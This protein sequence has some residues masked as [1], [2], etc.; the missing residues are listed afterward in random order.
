MTIP[1]FTHNATLK[2]F[3][4]GVLAL[5]LL[6]PTLWLDSLV[7][8]RKH[9][10]QEAAEEVYTMWG[11]PQ[12]IGS[13]I[14]V[15]P[16][17]YS[18][19]VEVARKRKTNEGWIEESI[20]KNSSCV[21]YTKLYPERLNITGDL[22]STQRK[23]GIFQI[24]LYTALIHYDFTYATPDWNRLG[25]NPQNIA[26]DEAYITLDIRDTRGLLGEPQL[27]VDG[28]TQAFNN[29]N[30]PGKPYESG[31]IATL[32]HAKQSMESQRPLQI[33][34]HTQGAEYFSLY[35]VARETKVNLQS[36]WTSPAFHGKY[37]P[38]QRTIE[39][40]GFNATWNLLALNHGINLA[41]TGKT[42]KPNEIELGFKQVQPVNYYSMT[43][44]A[45]KYV[46]LFIALTF[47]LCYFAERITGTSMHVLQYMLIGISLLLFYT[48][49]LSLSENVGFGKAYAM[50]TLA[51]AIQIALF[52]YKI[53]GS[54]VTAIVAMGV[55]SALYGFL[56]VLLTLE[57]HALLAGSIGLFTILGTLM[58]ISTRIPSKTIAHTP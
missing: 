11:G 23:K 13:P 10:S 32:P 34:I 22:P 2:L 28:Q 9:Y 55:L 50:A 21:G 6:I 58:Y 30:M 3:L 37:L 57:D 5:F 24:P 52:V 41:W 29:D 4:I 42:E 56:Y 49:L 7:S 38:N 54:R 39:A 15:L 16:Y 33:E 44:R 47:I 26:W 20:P 51:I 35:P 1:P 25:V 18:C 43:D 27:L 19:Y 14:L 53:M 31:L 40:S 46:I 48:L 45:I 12:E 8:E 36:D 17:H